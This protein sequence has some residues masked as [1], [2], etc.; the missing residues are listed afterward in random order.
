MLTTY[1]ILITLV[2]TLVQG[3]PKCNVQQPTLSVASENLIDTL[4][5]WIEFSQA[6]PFFILG[7]TDSRCA[8]KCCESEPLLDA[9]GKDF[10]AKSLTYPS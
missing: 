2:T 6:N 9:I 1:W 10:A 7:I 5:K 3:Q 4:E 8:P